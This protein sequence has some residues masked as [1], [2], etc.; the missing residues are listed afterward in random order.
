MSASGEAGLVARVR[1]GDAAAFGVLF[2]EHFSSL[3]GFVIS[4][5]KSAA[6]AEELVQDL[7][8]AIWCRRAE[9]YPVGQVRHYLLAAARNRAISHL[10]REGVAEQKVARWLV[11]GTASQADG[12]PGFGSSLPETDREAELAELADACRR[13]IQALPERQR[14]VVVFRW[15]HGMSHAAIAHAM[16]IS[17]KGVETQLT[18]A[19]KALRK[20]MERFR[21]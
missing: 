3:C 7:F 11:R 2:A 4:Y 14:V 15:Q 19:H 1:S 5:V 13:A 21:P 8:C 20:Y 9:W 10:R 12:L 16:G 18:R 17:V 6:V